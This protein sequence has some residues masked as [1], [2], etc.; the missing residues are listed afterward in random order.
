MKQTLAAP[1]RLGNLHNHSTPNSPKRHPQHG[2]CFAEE[3][4]TAAPK[5]AVFQR[6]YTRLLFTRVQPFRANYN[7]SCTL[8][9]FGSRVHPARAD[10]LEFFLLVSCYTRL[11]TIS[12]SEDSVCSQWYCPHITLP[13]HEAPE[14]RRDSGAVENISLAWTAVVYSPGR[15]FDH[16]RLLDILSSHAQPDNISF[17]VIAVSHRSQVIQQHHPQQSETTTARKGT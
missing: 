15:R 12:C 8:Q 7:A 5:T 2:E 16:S 14:P 13:Y 10:S 9:D 11:T 3:K 4:S 17:R 1:Y 6:K